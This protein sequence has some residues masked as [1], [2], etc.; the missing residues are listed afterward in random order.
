MICFRLTPLWKIKETEQWLNDLA[1]NGQVL[2]AVYGPF[3]HFSPYKDSKEQ[4]SPPAFWFGFYEQGLS[5]HGMFLWDA[6]YHGLSIPCHFN[7]Y[8]IDKY[9]NSKTRA[10]GLEEEWYIRRDLYAKGA[11]ENHIAMSLLC[12]V[13]FPF[14]CYDQGLKIGFWPSIVGFFLWLVKSIYGLTVISRRL[15]RYR[16]SQ[17]QEKR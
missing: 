13:A 1:A 10:R 7:Y 6:T 14:V 5:D 8:M 11:S 4:K 2:R 16:A 15:K 9:R 12:M 3:Y 17:I